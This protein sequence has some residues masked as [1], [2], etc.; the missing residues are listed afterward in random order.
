M[1]TQFQVGRS[2]YTRSLCDYDCIYRHTIKARTAKTVTIDY[3]GRE[4]RR[5]LSVWDGVE[6]FKPYGS[7]S[8]CAI[9]RADREG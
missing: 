8:M 2:Y 3:N 9:I 5:G 4:V 7:Y 6:Q 1:A